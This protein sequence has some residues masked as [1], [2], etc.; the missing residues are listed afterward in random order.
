MAYNRSVFPEGGYDTFPELYDLPPERIQDA[1][2]Y[3][4]LREKPS[5]TPQ[6]MQELN[7]L[8][9]T[10]D[11]YI[12]TPE[13][14][15]KIGDIATGTQKFFVENVQGYVETKQEEFDAEINKFTYKG[16]YNPTTQYYAKNYVTYNDGTGDN[17]FICV[18]NSINIDPTNATHWR[19]LGIKGEKGNDGI[20]LVFRGAWNN[21]SVYDAGDAV[22]Y[23]GVIFACMEAHI[24]QQPDLTQDTQYWAKAWDL[25]VTSTDMIGT[26]NITTSASNINFMTGEIIAFNPATDILSVYKNST[27][28]TKNVDY[29]IN[30]NNQS[31]DKIG[32]TWN[33]TVDQPVFF[34]FVVKRQQINGLVFSDGQSIQNGTITKNKLSTDVQDSLDEIGVL[35]NNLITTNQQLERFENEILPNKADLDI[36]GS[37]PV[38]QLGNISAWR[39][40]DEIEFDVDTTEIE[41]DINNNTQFKFILSNIIGMGSA[42]TSIDIRFHKTTATTSWYDSIKN[43]VISRTNASQDI[44]LLAGLPTGAATKPG[45]AVIDI[46]ISNNSALVV[47]YAGDPA[48]TAQVI[49]YHNE[50]NGYPLTKVY[51]RPN[52]FHFVKGTKVKIWGR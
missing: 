32:G 16:I 36:T 42:R 26:R 22:Q 39:K 38:S 12:L 19:K 28:L 52:S 23:G 43:G 31:I 13:K 33:G 3:K 8:S 14:Y 45:I 10:L 20:G 30:P 7:N 4:A 25:M 35:S 47:G 50:V 2:R 21:S 51:I 49:G 6:E 48:N 1:K 34:E 46:T 44:K 40:I 5:K 27:R 41:I 24:N 18:V 29:V 9:I 11:P 15:N 17:I 37:V